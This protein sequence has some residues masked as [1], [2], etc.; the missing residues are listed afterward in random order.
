MIEELNKV[1]PSVGTAVT[2]GVFDGVHLG[3]QQLIQRTRE[4]A[5][6]RGLQTVVLT[7]RNH[8]RTVLTPGFKPKYLTA[9]EE[10]VDLIKSLGI[11]FVAAIT[12]TKEVSQLRAKEFVSLLQKHCKMEVLVVG[13]DF[14]LGVNRE[15]DIETLTALGSEMGFSVVPIEFAQ[16]YGQE[17]SST[18]IREALAAGDVVKARS[19]QGRPFSLTGQVVG[20]DKRGKLLGFPTANIDVEETRA[21]PAD[22]I[23]ATRA[24]FAGAE[25]DS[26]TYI[27]TRPT[28]GESNRV[29]E[30]FIL[31]FQ[32][33]LYGQNL[34]IEFIDRIRGDM[35][36]VN[37]D[38]LVTQMKKDVAQAQEV[39]AKA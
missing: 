20:G 26:A 34:T 33:E 39:L 37:P 1:T 19:Y 14:A 17:V 9:I 21:I 8:P 10:R 23:Y 18:S 16:L 4:I 15:G 12:F 30:V 11:D 32:G 5:A 2:I 38:D 31:D 35:A 13:P 29:I 7:F 36:F 3:H 25:H 24:C 22:G 27:G 6:E 28:F